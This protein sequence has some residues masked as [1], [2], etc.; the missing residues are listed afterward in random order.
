MKALG[1]SEARQFFEQAAKGAEGFSM[2]ELMQLRVDRY[3]SAPG[4]LNESDG[5]NC[6]LCQNRGNTAVLIERGGAYFDSYPPCRCMEIRRSIWRLK[7]SGLENSIRDCTFERFE[8]MAPWQQTM[9]DTAK[10]YLEE[11]VQQGRWFFVG[12]Q[13]GS[14][15][16]H[17][18]TAISRQLLYESPLRYMAWEQESK[19]LKA[20]VNDAEEYGPEIE[21]YKTVTV[22]YI[23]DLFKPVKDE[24]GVRRP[25]TPAD[26][27]L[28]FEI[29]NHRY[30]NRL[31]T[32][33]S[34]EW[35]MDELTDLD[36]ATASR[37]AERCGPFQLV[38][39]N[40]KAKNHRFSTQTML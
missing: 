38:I 32:I 15:K 14:G 2:R 25:P 16:T 19:R 30:I 26:L 3:N 6:K 35:Y 39:G 24:Y 21:K 13:P 20:I 33:L 23:D 40:D 8:V 34:S 36:E 37:I 5:Y 28:A 22:L 12:G 27:K 17:I 7:Q 29:L 4:N 18:C 11:G 9:V 1:V 31:P 10:R